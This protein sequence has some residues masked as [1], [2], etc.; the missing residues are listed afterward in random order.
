MNENNNNNNN[1]NPTTAETPKAEPKNPETVETPKVEPEV[2]TNPETDAVPV[3]E[4]TQSGFF[5]RN[6]KTIA[7]ITGGVVA[8][9]AGIA[10]ALL[11]GKEKVVAAAETVTDAAGDAAKATGDAVA[12]VTETVVG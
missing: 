3:V 12:D 4:P 11:L 7:W 2:D 1:V 10:G 9:G 6:W 5:K 8:V